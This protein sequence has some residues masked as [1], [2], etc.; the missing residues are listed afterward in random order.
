MLSRQPEIEIRLCSHSSSCPNR[1]L[2]QSTC[3]TA[4]T[5]RNH[6][7]SAFLF[8]T[9]VLCKILILVYAGQRQ[10]YDDACVKHVSATHLTTGQDMQ[11]AVL[12]LLE[13]ALVLCRFH[14]L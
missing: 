10:L 7:H 12:N 14:N 5:Q 4:N 2:S 11:D 1:G 9:R 13:L 6:L 8:G 3:C